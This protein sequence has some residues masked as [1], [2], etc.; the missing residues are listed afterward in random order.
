MRENFTTIN[1]CDFEYEVTGGDYNLTAGDLLKVL[2]MVVYVLNEN[3]Q[4]IRTIRMWRGDFGSALSGRCQA[5]LPLWRSFAVRQSLQT[6]TFRQIRHRAL[7][8][9]GER[10]VP[11]MQDYHTMARPVKAANQADLEGYADAS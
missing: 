5:A 2:C 1:A 9:P 6:P 8:G 10:F 3:L 7:F 11:T 4:H